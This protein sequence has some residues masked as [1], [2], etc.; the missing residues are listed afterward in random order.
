MPK[1]GAP[2]H[3]GDFSDFDHRRVRQVVDLYLHGHV[4]P[5]YDRDDLYQEARISWLLAEPQFDSGRGASR[6]TFI[7][8]VVTNRLRD[9]ARESRAQRRWQPGGT[10]SLDVPATDDG[11]DLADL[12]RDDAP[13]PE[14]EAIANDLLRQLDAVRRGLLPRQQQVL[15]ALVSDPDL[16]RA[17]LARDLGIARDTLY[18]DIEA[19]RAA[20][21]D[22]GLH[23]LL[24]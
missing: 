13:G 19:I 3:S 10:H 18:M 6:S 12:L 16:K 9:L 24:S 5:G 15:D 21:R 7:G 11:D 2:P 20:C 17:P 23:D 8:R 4:I 14:Y 22:A 1:H